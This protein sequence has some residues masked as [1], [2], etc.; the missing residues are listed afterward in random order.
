ME[1]L[2]K[3]F[4]ESSGVSIDT[5]T[6]KGGELFFCLKGDR[7]NG[8][9]FAS[10]ALEAGASF[11]IVDDA[12]YYIKNAAMLLVDD[13][14]KVLQELSKY[15]RGQLTIPIIGIT[16]TN[17]KTTTKELINAVLSSHFQTLSTNGN[18]NNHIGVPLTLLRIEDKHQIAVIEMGANHVGEI[19]DLCKLSQP[20]F[21]LITNIGKAHLEGFGSFENI[22]KTKT[23]LYHSIQQSSGTVFLNADDELLIKESE[24]LQQV[25][26]SVKNN[27]TI[28]LELQ[29]SDGSLKFSWNN[30]SVK[31]QLFG[32]YN[33][34]NAAA[35][36]A[37]GEYFKIPSAKI[38]KALEEYK[39]SNN[40]SQ[41]V[42]GDNNELILDAYNANPDSM[43]QAL[44]FFNR[45]SSNKKAVVLGDMLEL[46]KHE[47][48]EHKRVLDLLDSMNFD[49]VF[50]VGSAFSKQKA[51]Y[52]QFQFFIDNID[53]LEY[54]KMNHLKGYRILLK[55]SRGISLEL[56]KH[57]LL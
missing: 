53:A 10:Q 19:A 18:F 3:R 34:Y 49:E 21:G 16:G 56:L 41:L 24:G 45:A 35:A 52:P 27:S 17:G 32:E 1:K 36:I 57:Q 55:G 4:K 7:F 51:N 23:A 39:P 11:I 29:A 38:I 31:T 8:N 15:H 20:N 9:K 43:K 14:L 37:V 2:Y 44:S 30:V 13:S 42:E 46:G 26:Y 6:I 47:K 5:R 28:R 22:I 50:L 12:N 48:I 25:K 40:R 33:I 54:F